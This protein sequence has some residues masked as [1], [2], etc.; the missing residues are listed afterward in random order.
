M[1]RKNLTATELGTPKRSQ[2]A[3]VKTDAQHYAQ[4]LE[5][6]HQ[7]GLEI[8]DHVQPKQIIQ[9]AL[10]LIFPLVDSDG[11]AF[12]QQNSD[13]AE[14]WNELTISVGKPGLP[15]GTRFELDKGMIG[16]VFDSGESVV[17]DDFL[18]PEFEGYPVRTSRSLM[19]VPLIRERLVTGVF[20]ICHADKP[21]AFDQNDLALL[22]RFVTLVSIALENG[23]LLE[24]SQESTASAVSRAQQLEALHA[25]SLEIV[26]END[27]IS[28]IER[29]L[30][31][32]TTLVDADA[33]GYWRVQRPWQPLEEPYLEVILATEKVARFV[34]TK[35]DL[36]QPG[37]VAHVIQTG[38]SERVQD[39]LNSKYRHPQ[40]QEPWRS[41]IAVPL[42]HKNQIDGVFVLIH[43]DKIDFF[44]AGHVEILERFA[45]L[46]A[47]SLENARLL[48]HSREIETQSRRRAQI[49]EV[50]HEFSL[51]LMGELAPK[52]LLERI[53]NRAAQLIQ[54][55][56]CAI[57]LLEGQVLKLA[58]KSGIN[59]SSELA[60]GQGVLG[61]VAQTRQPF[62]VNN[63]NQSTYR[64]Q[65]A[66]WNAIMGVP[67]WHNNNI[68]GVLA[69]ADPLREF[70]DSDLDTLERFA[71]LASVAI[72][73]ARVYENL[74][75]AE[76][77]AQQQNTLLAALH[78]ANLELSASLEP[79]VLLDSLLERAV[80]LLQG[81]AGR[82]YLIEPLTSSLKL[83][84]TR[85]VGFVFEQ[86]QFGQGLA[87]RIAERNEGM[88]IDDYKN[89][90]GG[91][92][93][94]GDQWCSTIGVP[95]RRGEQAIGALL[96]AD[97][98]EVNR[99]GT[100]ELEILERF[101]A[102]AVI[103]LENARLFD[104]AKT[105]QLEAQ[106]SRLEA[107]RRAQQLEAVYQTS[108]ELSGQL[109][110][111]AV[112]TVLVERVATLFLADT[113]AVYFRIPGTNQIELKANFGTSPTL[114]GTLGQG[115]SGRVVESGEPKV[116]S[117]YQTW[118]GRDFNIPS[119]LVWRSA[120]SAPITRGSQVIGALSIADTRFPDRFSDAQLEMLERFAAFASVALENA[121]LHEIE[122]GNLR[123][124]RLRSQIA[125]RLSP[126]RAIDELCDAVLEELYN[127]LGYERIS[128][129]L[130]HGQTL[131]LQA[132]RGFENAVRSFS[133]DQGIIGR[134][135]R[136]RQ[137]QIVPDPLLDPDYINPDPNPNPGALICLPIH[138]G[139]RDL[140]VLN[141]GLKK[142]EILQPADLE[143]LESLL[144]TISAAL[145]NSVLH[146]ELEARAAELELLRE[147]AEQAA[148]HD[149]LTGLANRRAIER[150]LSSARTEGTIFTLAALDLTGFKNVNDQLGHDA[151]DDA[152]KRIASVLN[153]TLETLQ[154][155]SG[156]KGAFRV[157]GDE[158]LMLIPQPR[159]VALELCR[160]VLERITQLDFPK[161]LRVST[162]IGLAEYPTEAKTIDALFS[163]ADTRMY[164]A[165]RVGMPFLEGIELERPPK[166]KRRQTDN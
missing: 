11:G 101:A 123:E 37:L 50:M 135:M 166:P 126:L 64:L 23:R 74:H 47:V 106:N 147:K 36:I 56:A 75:H 28:V 148:S 131:S 153:A 121:R 152:L 27:L 160:T 130:L 29:A 33:G 41:V 31:L 140:G 133:I 150:T 5:G 94:A 128:L 156:M 138:S 124:E 7:I 51:E 4:Q 2:T 134:A 107:Q 57:Y 129:F 39:Y 35:I 63:Y 45:A 17:I 104:T 112:L 151:G 83:E 146:F 122:R 102:L 136:T 119:P 99:Y 127:A 16:Q 157:G 144:P 10:E 89:W 103:A 154:S 120:M 62:L 76:R 79:Q 14:S 52:E 81:G 159:H 90:S 115:L 132:K 19:F 3:R 118:Q 111:D 9:R 59:I 71:A 82:L 12:W 88:I 46:C 86:M 1:R 44:S 93:R 34:G 85:G 24:K 163:L 53:L 145:E 67:L 158:F 69:L 21:A 84:A 97:T 32:A 80:Q 96:V 8:L 70:T 92:P 6:L 155:E 116:V 26:A 139:N 87:G 66:D 143:M 73:N 49:L 58:A 110:P 98:H 142:G 117:D 125:R 95:L 164:A 105:A 48:T 78:D 40:F 55:D 60:V 108:L 165:K 54:V 13:Q 161:R 43:S 20:V 77:A 65:G 18:A 100:T 25:L 113:G 114:S 149:P 22:K 30:K 61:R 72:E 141:F 38:R 42:W 91:L 162:N 137:V 68:T 15:V 109:E